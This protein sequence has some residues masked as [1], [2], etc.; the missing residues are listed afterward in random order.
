MTNGIMPKLEY[1]NPPKYDQYTKYRKYLRKATDFSCAYCTISESESP[2][3]TFNIDHFRPQKEFPSLEASCENLR[4]TCPRCNSYKR[5]RWIQRTAG[6]IRDCKTCTTHVC[7][8]NIP[9]FIDTLKELP[10]EHIF[11]NEDDMLCAYS[12]SNPASYTIKYLRLNR[13]QLVKLRHTRRFM[14][15]WL[16]DL[17]KKRELAANRLS[18]LEMQK[19]DFLSKETSC[20]E[21]KT[22]LHAD[23]LKT[24]Y[25]MVTTLAEQTVLMID[26]EIHK[27]NILMEKHS[28]SDEE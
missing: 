17:L 18:E 26:E 9:R 19:Q 22:D 25:E 1:L 11:L 5:S 8:E 10:S 2:G 4:Y 21:S 16:D 7:K 24:M 12:G 27:L 28:G 20:N 6:C 13:A 3:A 14:D 23:M 15:S